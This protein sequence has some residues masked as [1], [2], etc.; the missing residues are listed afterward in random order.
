MSFYPTETEAH[1]A[2]D[3][4]LQQELEDFWEMGD[5]FKDSSE[6]LTKVLQWVPELEDWIIVLNRDSADDESLRLRLKIPSGVERYVEAWDLT[7][8][9]STFTYLGSENAVT[10]YIGPN[11]WTKTQ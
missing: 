11:D 5:E 10:A 6:L 2:L 1:K 7:I 4:L 3:E 9:Y 8:G